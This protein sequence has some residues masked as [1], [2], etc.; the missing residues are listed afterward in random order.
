MKLATIICSQRKKDSTELQ[1]ELGT[2]RDF[3]IESDNKQTSR[4]SE[5]KINQRNVVKC[6]ATCDDGLS[7]LP[8]FKYLRQSKHYQREACS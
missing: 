5:K 4:E 3:S 2:L 6:L 8:H 1:G 7:L